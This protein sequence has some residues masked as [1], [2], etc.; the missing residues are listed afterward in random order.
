[1]S[2]GI[3]AREG[4]SAGQWLA[5]TA[6]LIVIAAAAVITA[7]PVAAVALLLSPLYL[8][9]V[10]FVLG[11]ALEHPPTHVGPE[12]LPEAQFLPSFT[13]LV[14]LFR[15]ARVAGQLIGALSDI[16]YADDRLQIIVLLEEDD[17]ETFAAFTARPLPARIEIAIVPAGGPRTKP[18][19]LNHGLT[20]ARGEFLTVFDAEDLPDPEQ[21]LQAAA[22]F[23]R[24]PPSTV[25]LQARLVIDNAPDGW[26][27]LMMSIEY[28]ALFDATKCGLAAMAMPVVLGGTSNHFRREALMA[29]GG[30]DAW[31]VTEDAD[32]GLRIAQHGWLVADLPST[33]LEEAPFRLAGWFHQRRRWLKGFIQ[34][35]V[36]HT[37]HPRR[38]IAAMGLMNWAAGLMQVAGAMGG[39]LL[40]PVFTV[41]MA[42]QIAT[43]AIF[44]N[45]DWMSAALNTTAL[46][47]ASCGLLSA[48]VP[49]LI[50][51]WRR[52]IWHLAPWLLM[53][54]VYLLLISAAAWAAMV[55]YVREPFRW[56]KT[57]HGLGIR[58]P[59]AFRS[60]RESR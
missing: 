18:N 3:S 9:H 60:R 26:L 53:L 7:K 16:R 40:F 22:L 41:H 23:S 8:L 42:S 11:A 47:V 20:L 2:G 30:W 36:S 45:A 6:V 21:L 49:A 31:N 51:L 1:M 24:L 32:I 56:H 58:R 34:T 28:A 4:A 27:A 12:P 17:G 35:F 43:G 37:R 39:A 13:V 46:W 33:T 15:E 14:P 59:E 52:R 25:C 57:E 29:L 50:G 19:A 44:D 48:T 10:F 55:D 38:S 54:P 5:F